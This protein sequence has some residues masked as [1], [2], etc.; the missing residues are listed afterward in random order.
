MRVRCGGGNGASAVT[1]C[2]H[3]KLFWGAR[4]GRRWKNFSFGPFLFSNGN[5]LPPCRG[6]TPPPPIHRP[7]DP[8][9]HLCRGQVLLLIVSVVMSERSE[10]KIFFLKRGVGSLTV[11]AVTPGRLIGGAADRGCGRS[12]SGAAVVEGESGRFLRSVCRNG[13][14]ASRSHGVAVGSAGARV[15]WIVPD[16]A[17]SKYLGCW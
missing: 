17:G 14:T 12:R 7:A 15:V 8:Q 4:E 2:Q 16:F 3:Q 1:T 10:R 13:V 11:G 5:C 6:R 9:Y